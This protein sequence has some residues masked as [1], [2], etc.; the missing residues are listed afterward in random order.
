M[1]INYEFYNRQ[2][3]DAILSRGKKAA[4]KVAG[5]TLKRVLTALGLE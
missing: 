2:I 3:L 5:Q 1:K 4:R